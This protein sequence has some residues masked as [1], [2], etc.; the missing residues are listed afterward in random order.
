MDL[1]PEQ[2]AAALMIAVGDDVA[3]QL[4]GYLDDEEVEA[5]AAEIAQLER[6]DPAMLDRVLDEVSHEATTT[7]AQGGMDFVKRMLTRWNGDIGSEI[8]DEL[9]ATEGKPFKFVRTIDPP[10]IVSALEE[11]HPQVLAVVIA[12]QPPSVAARLLQTL[13][14]DVRGNVAI[15]VARFGRV[16]K[17]A[18][19]AVEKSL[20]ER[21]GSMAGPG[22]R[23]RGGAHGLAK[24][25]NSSDKET[26][27]Q[28]LDDLH[29]KD[30]T[31]AKEVRSLMFVFE[32]IQK[33]DDRA[34]QRVLADVDTQSLAVALKGATDE[35]TNRILGNMS[36]RARDL[37]VEEIDL[38]GPVPRT[39]IE[40]ARDAIASTVLALAD[41]DEVS[42]GSGGGEIVE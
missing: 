24:V 6:I 35:L 28:I 29:E 9:T 12:H 20:I 33:L 18:V 34:I 32:D 40:E 17:K 14:E 13:P 31:L 36:Q 5:L 41:A 11:E 30:P 26:E 19:G 39:E 7:A 42:I 10:L 23:K 4:L 3:S 15:R 22:G 16:S 25:L 8:V 21:L 37:L 38:L 2:K 27:K 1:R